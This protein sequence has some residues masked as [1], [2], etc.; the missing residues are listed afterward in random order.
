MKTSRINKSLW[1][2]L[3]ACQLQMVLAFSAPFRLEVREG[4][5]GEENPPTGSATDGRVVVLRFAASDVAS[6][7]QISVT[8]PVSGGVYWLEAGH[9][10]Q[11]QGFSDGGSFAVFDVEITGA[12]AGDYGILY[13]WNGGV[14]W[15]PIPAQE[16]FYESIR[17]FDDPDNRALIAGLFGSGMAAALVPAITAWLYRGAFKAASGVGIPEA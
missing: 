4:W 17:A 3:C 7:A 16:A 6:A 1:L 11:I 8:N 13:L 12:A 9:T 15:T 14:E 2:W 10:W 5:F